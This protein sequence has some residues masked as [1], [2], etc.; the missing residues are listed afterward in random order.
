[1]ADEP[2][3]EAP[4]TEPTAPKHEDKDVDDYDGIQ[5]EVDKHFGGSWESFLKAV[6]N[7]AEILHFVLT[8]H[9]ALDQKKFETWANEQKFP[10]GWIQR[11]YSTLT[12]EGELK[13]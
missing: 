5:S 12:P 4:P 9:F 2:E 8:K 3:A 13:R 6:E 11:F 7:P 1:M 10:P